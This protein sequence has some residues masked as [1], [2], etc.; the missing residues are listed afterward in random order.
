[1][2]LILIQGGIY[3]FEI[4]EEYAAGGIPLMTAGIC[5]LLAISYF[6]GIDQL[7][8]DFEQMLGFKPLSY[9]K[10]MNKYVIPVVLFVILSSCIIEWSPVK[11]LKYE[12][13][14]W[15]H[16]IGWFLTLSSIIWIPLYALGYLMF[17]PKTRQN[18]PLQLNTKD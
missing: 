9:T 1:M 15:A 5:E 11:Y 18:E 4:F 14:W 13:P 8:K 6:Y 2:F 7:W 16:T 10:W 17:E 3:L 12:Y